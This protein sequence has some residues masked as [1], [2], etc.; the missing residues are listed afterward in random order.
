MEGITGRKNEIRRLTDCYNSGKAEFVALYGR[1]RIGKTYLVRNMFRDKFAFEMSGSIDADSDTQLSNFTR[2]L[3]DYGYESNEAPHT[4]HEAFFA[5]RSLLKDKTGNGQRLLIFIDELPCLDTPKSGFIQAFEHFWNSWAS[6]HK[7]IMLIVCGSA[8]SWM[9]SNLIDSHGGLHNRITHEI[10]LAPFTLAETEEFLTGKGFCWHRLTMLQM[11][12]IMGGVPYYLGLLEK[13]KSPEA[14]IDRLFF[15]EHGELKR[16]YNRLYSSLF[17]NSELYMKVIEA[18]ASC[19]QGLTRK[20]ISQKVKSASG[21]TLTKIIKEL[22]NCDFIRGYN[23]RERKIKQKEQIYQ[24]TDLYTLFYMQFCHK[25]TTDEHFWTNM[26]GKPLQNTWYGLSFERICMLHIPQI[27]KKLGIDR[28]HTEYYSWRS[29]ISEPAAQIDLIIERADKL[30]NIC[31]IKYSQLPYAIT[32]E[33]DMRIR[34]RIA[35]FV[36]ETNIRTGIITTIIT[37]FGIKNNAY[38]SAAQATLT[39]DDLFV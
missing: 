35:D 11:Y 29:R 26:M 21:G 30:T 14:N 25:A 32:K 22:V 7:E 37:T 6:D 4:W 10:H 38:A 12:S 13:D 39:M 20:Q 2:A 31:E 5:L 28:I 16:E 15:A 27:K 24:L 36:C 17:R 23:T 3:Y 33:E 34:N 18:L 8:T 19:K 1:R 9:I